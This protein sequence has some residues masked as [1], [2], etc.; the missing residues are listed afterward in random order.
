[1]DVGGGDESMNARESGIF[2]RVGGTAHIGFGRPAETRNNRFAARL[3]D[4]LNRREIAVR[5]NCKTGFDD[6]Y[7]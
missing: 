5:C 2:Q 7:A 3:S 4:R 1:M 6:I